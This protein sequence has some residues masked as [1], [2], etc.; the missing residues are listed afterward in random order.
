[1]EDNKVL[2]KDLI[3]SAGKQL[4]TE[5]EE[6]RAN[7]PHA[8][9]SGTEVEMILKKFLDDRLP[10]RFGVE[11]GFVVGQDGIVS[12]QTDLIV[13][14]ALNSP[15]YRKGPKTHILHRDNVA[16]ALE[17]KSKLNKEEL[18]DAAKKIASVKKLKASPVNSADR[19][20]TFSDMINT[21]VLGCVFAFDSYT[22]LETLA[23]NLKE[24]NAE[25]DSSNWIDLICVLDKGIIG[26]SL[27][28]P[29]DKDFA[30][31]YA[32]TCTDQ[33]P[34]PP[35]YIHLTKQDAGE[36]ALN[37]FFIRVISHLTFFRERMAVD[38]NEAL[39]SGNKEAMT[40]QGYQYNTSGQLVEAEKT[41]Q[42]GSFQ[43]PKVR[44]NLYRRDNKH[45]I[46]QVCLMPWQDGAVITCS[47][48]ID[49]RIIYNHYFKAIKGK[50]IVVPGQ[51]S[52]RK[53]PIHLSS[54]MNISEEKF[55]ELS[56]NIH[57]DIISKRDADGDSCN[58][59]KR[60]G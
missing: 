13:F 29:F 46:G 51:L 47:A 1:M 33:F 54:V 9:D 52:Q 37:H 7:N 55:I 15:V 31:V 10:K 30:G 11:S 3:I 26:Y 27:Q 28:A 20:V 40:L 50:H 4:R 34:I 23:E 12:R 17:V 42:S 56:A 22:S 44:F 53:S 38:L 49:Y 5:F 21:N 36:L 39:G 45:L 24:I 14:D 43:N 60:W 35:F 8:G 41:H 57:P 48:M 32:G 58:G 59:F 19:P 16:V 6:I 25:E 18:K 2:L